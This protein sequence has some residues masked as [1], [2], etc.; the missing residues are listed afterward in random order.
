MTVD[1]WLTFLLLVFG[2]FLVL[3]GVFTAYFGSGRSRSIGV[4]LLVGGS[5][6]G[7]RRPICTTRTSGTFAGCSASRSS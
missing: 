1:Q 4:G 2:L 6:S 7:S 5:W 3:A